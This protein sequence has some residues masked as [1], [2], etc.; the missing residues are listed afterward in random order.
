MVLFRITIQ[1]VTD[2]ASEHGKWQTIPTV[3]H[4]GR[5]ASTI[6]YVKADKIR[7]RIREIEDKDEAT[8]VASP[9]TMERWFNFHTA[10]LYRLSS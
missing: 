10:S 7:K 6:R 8:A 5:L 3:L 4:R 1:A 2:V 9:R